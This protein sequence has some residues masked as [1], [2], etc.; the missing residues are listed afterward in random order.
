MVKQIRPEDFWE[1]FSDLADPRDE[2]RNKRHLLKD[3]VVIAIVGFAVGMKA[4]DA[5][6]D[7]A[8]AQE[9]WFKQYLKLPNGIPS[10]DTFERVFQALDPKVFG[11]CF[12]QWTMSVAQQTNG[13]IIAVDGKTVRNRGNAAQRALP[14]VSAWSHDNGLVLGQISCEEKS[15]EITAIPNLLEMLVLKWNIV[16]IDAMGCQKDIIRAVV[17]KKVDYLVSVKD[18][19][20]NLHAAVK[21]P[22]ELLGKGEL[23]DVPVYYHEE[24]ET[25]HGR[26]ATRRC[27]ATDFV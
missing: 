11:K 6:A 3:I 19:E 22:F 23:A 27:W 25:G 20:P 5:I 10:H 14:I 9:S 8:R 21:Q 4:F 2:G 7:F 18:N 26:Q 24:S 16:T 13:A 17:D 15:N 1:Y 12:T